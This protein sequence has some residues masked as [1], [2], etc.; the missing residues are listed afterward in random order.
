MNLDAIVRNAVATVHNITLSLQGEVKHYA[1]FDS[2]AYG[3]NQY[4]LVR[5]GLELVGSLDALLYTP[6]PA[7]VDYRQQIRNVGGK[8]VMSFAYLAFL[9]PITGNDVSRRT[10]VID[11]RDVIVLPDGKTG[12]IIDV[13]G[14]MDRGTSKPFFHEVW[15]GALEG[16]SF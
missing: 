8:A 13:K 15:L 14:F 5:D 9:E 3:K 10:G 16:L 4:Y 11:T 6:R 1:W 7:I 2:D 12:P